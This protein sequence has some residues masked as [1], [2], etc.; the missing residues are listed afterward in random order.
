MDVVWDGITRSETLAGWG[1]RIRQRLADRTRSYDWPGALAILSEHPEYVN[2]TRPGG[3]SLYAPLHQAAHGGAPARVIV[4]LLNLGAWRTLQNARGE[5]PVDIARKRGHGH[6]IPSLEPV[7]ERQVPLGIL[8]TVQ[9]HPRG[10]PRE[11]QR[12]R[13]GARAA[14][15]GTRAAAGDEDPPGLVRDTRYVRGLQLPSG[16]GRRRAQAGNREL[17]PGRGWLGAASRDHPRG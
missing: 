13:R 5:R 4:D 12:T 10:Y 8:L 6:L 11:G 16:G 14:T 7:L 1:L 2:A 15:T 17:V 9:E 3:Q